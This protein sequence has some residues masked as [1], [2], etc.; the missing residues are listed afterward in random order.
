MAN[1]L[2]TRDGNCTQA[3]S[4]HEASRQRQQHPTRRQITP[5]PRSS[6]VIQLWLHPLARS[7]QNEYVGDVD[8]FFGG[9]GRGIGIREIKMKTIQ[10]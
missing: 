9:V 10:K 8:L 2:A 5:A 3:T 4:D 6:Q 7:T 1:A